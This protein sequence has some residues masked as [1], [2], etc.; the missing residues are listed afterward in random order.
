MMLKMIFKLISELIFGEFIGFNLM[1]LL[2]K[3]FCKVGVVR[4]AIIKNLLLPKH[5]FHISIFQF[6]Q[7]SEGQKRADNKQELVGTVEYPGT[8]VQGLEMC[9]WGILSREVI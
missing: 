8:E 4:L 6:A 3:D 2:R 5:P 7:S 9:N 1:V